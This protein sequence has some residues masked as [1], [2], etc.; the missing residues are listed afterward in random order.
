MQIIF[1]LCTLFWMNMT[2][3]CI[4]TSTSVCSVAI[5][6]DG[7][8]VVSRISKQGGNHAQLLPCFVEELM[9]EGKSQGLTLD[10]V[11]LSEGPGSY[12]GLRIGASLAK[13]VCY[14]LDIPLLP[15]PTTQVL[16]ASFISH[17]TPNTTHQT[18]N[19]LLCPLIDARRMEVYTALYTPQLE[20]VG[21]VEAKIVDA[22]SWQTE[23]KEHDIYFFGDGAMKCAQTIISEHAH[24]IAD[25][26]PEAQYMG[27]I[28][29]SLPQEAYVKG[30]AL[31][32]FDPLYVKEFV[33][34][35][36]HVKGLD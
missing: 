28:A 14:G 4:E 7:R 33:P 2:L 1:Y 21:Q 11:A 32:Y 34:A 24:F 15:L 3:L 25:I 35:P 5:V 17:Q 22:E 26:V 30:K 36:S 10:G 12:T 27:L 23:L 29:E 8:S 20:Q 13:G 16:A 9:A 18:P 31:A 19:I 6:K